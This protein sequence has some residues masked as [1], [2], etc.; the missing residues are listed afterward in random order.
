M[1][2]PKD[3]W[4]KYKGKHVQYIGNGVAD[5]GLKKG[6][7]A[8]V[9]AYRPFA[10]SKIVLQADNGKARRL[11][12]TDGIEESEKG[13]DYD[14]GR[15]WSVKVETLKTLEGAG[16]RV[17]TELGEGKITEIDSQGL[18]CVELDADKERLY[19]FRYEELVMLP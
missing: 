13:I 1:L 16:I 11:D 10:N 17:K 12:D 14:H 7:I 8:R 2:S 4:H 18:V 19:E 3:F 9:I 5:I 6:Q 15:G